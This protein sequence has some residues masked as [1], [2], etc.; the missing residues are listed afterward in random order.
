MRRQ[1][2][3]WVRYTY[4]G[5]WHLWAHTTPTGHRAPVVATMCR[6]NRASTSADWADV[7]KWHE[8]PSPTCPEC[9]ELYHQVGGRHE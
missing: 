6:R 1:S 5:L 4:R 2:T 3:T 8:P 7:D 9:A